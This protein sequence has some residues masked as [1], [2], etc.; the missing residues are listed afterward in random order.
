LAELV[1]HDIGPRGGR[2]VKLLGDDIMLHF[3]D[4]AEA[5]PCALV[6][7]DRVQEALAARIADY[8]RPREVVVSAEVAELTGAASEFREIGPVN[9]KGMEG[10]V[11]L[12][13]AFAAQ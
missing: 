2:I 9:L 6:L 13:T 4:A 1:Q 3:A 11:T 10:P 5:V 12:L 7:V 8:A